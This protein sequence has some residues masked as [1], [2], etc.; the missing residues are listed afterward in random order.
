M[1]NH[2]HKER[3]R[4]PQPRDRNLLH[5]NKLRQARG[6]APLVSRTPSIVPHPDGGYCS[7]LTAP[8]A[9]RTYG[10]TPTAENDLPP[11]THPKDQKALE[12]FEEALKGRKPTK[13]RTLSAETIQ[14]KNCSACG[15][16]HPLKITPLPEPRG[17]YT[18]HGTCENTQ[19]RVLYASNPTPSTPE[20]PS[21]TQQTQQHPTKAAEANPNPTQKA[22]PPA[23]QPHLENWYLYGTDPKN[24]R[25]SGET[26]NDRRFR[27]GER[28]DTS[29]ITEINH[30]TKT[31]ITKNTTYTLGRPESGWLTALLE[32]GEH[33]FYLFLTQTYSEELNCAATA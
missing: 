14:V 30:Q 28:I 31:V 3:T 6:K 16:N 27:D 8:P 11:S 26:Q 13:T 9:P 1:K 2:K 33:D 32:K 7:V 5:R 22:A 4:S 24:L 19:K 17:E 29:P 18:H 23:L 15:K 10:Q 21:A 20:V 12:R 25:V